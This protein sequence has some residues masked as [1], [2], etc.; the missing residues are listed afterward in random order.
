MP[1]SR[2]SHPARVDP[3]IARF[4][5]L[6]PELRVESYKTQIRTSSPPSD[7]GTPRTACAPTFRRG[8]SRTC[9]LWQEPE[10]A[11]NLAST[12]GAM[13]LDGKQWGVPYSYYQWGVYYREDI[14]N[15]GAR[16]EANCAKSYTA[17]SAAFDYLNLR[18][19]PIDA[20]TRHYVA[21]PGR[22]ALDR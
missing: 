9:D 13:T 21:H 1:P 20:A 15:L 17:P 5:A 16:D 3:V 22:G 8:C 18:V 6:H 11:E 19:H 12:K 2:R 4:G 7:A 10:I 14:F